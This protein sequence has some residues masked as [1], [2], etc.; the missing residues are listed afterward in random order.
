[1]TAEIQN[2]LDSFELLSA[3]EQ[4]EVAREILLRMRNVDLPPLS[5]ED[6]VLNAEALFLELDR[7]EGA[8]A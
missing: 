1:M 6:L 4:Q 5:N 7:R 3:E 2:L 8:D